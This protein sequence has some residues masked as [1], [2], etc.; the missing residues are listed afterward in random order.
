VARSRNPIAKAV[1][2]L[3]VRIV[4][5]GKIYSRKGRQPCDGN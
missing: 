2:R 1:T 4:R 5:S 3:H